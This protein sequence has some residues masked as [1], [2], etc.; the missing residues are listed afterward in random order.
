MAIGVGNRGKCEVILNAHDLTQWV[1][2]CLPYVVPYNAYGHAS[3][4]EHWASL[5]SKT[6]LHRAIISFNCP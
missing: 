5:N 6:T 3:A 2:V 4:A 1:I